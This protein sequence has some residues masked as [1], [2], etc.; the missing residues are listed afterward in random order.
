MRPASPRYVRVRSHQPLLNR[1]HQVVGGVKGRR[2]ERRIGAS[3]PEL[4]QPDRLSQ[5]IRSVLGVGQS[6]RLDLV[7]QAI[8]LVHQG[9]ASRLRTLLVDG[10]DGYRGHGSN[11]V[12]AALMSSH[13]LQVA[14]GPGSESVLTGWVGSVR[15]DL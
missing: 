4:K 11:I 1:E 15:I 8:R 6:Q 13:Y 14:D 10:V 2:R 5:R 9:P 7:E 3:E 12:A